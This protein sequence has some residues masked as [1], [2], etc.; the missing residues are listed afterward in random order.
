[1]AY[2]ISA[3][4]GLVIIASVSGVPASV[5]GHTRMFPL[6]GVAAVVLLCCAV[7]IGSPKE[8]SALKGKDYVCIIFLL[9][10]L[11]DI[12]FPYGL[13]NV[14]IY[15]LIMLFVVLRGFG[16]IKFTLI[17]AGCMCASFIGASWGY[18]QYFGLLSSNS[19]YHL[20]TGP[21]HN[22]AVLASMLALLLG[23][24]V[25]AVIGFYSFLRKHPFFF[26]S[27]VALIIL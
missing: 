17:F 1:M 14:G 21:F 19:E 5:F 9:L 12:R 3:L 6:F 16:Q 10:Y 27:V 7:F 25:N 15:C 22:P 20:L 23:V 13:W 26:A 4:L 2:L 24:M 8:I 18:L 11:V